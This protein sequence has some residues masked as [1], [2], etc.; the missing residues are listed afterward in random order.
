[1]HKQ[2]KLKGQKLSKSHASL[3]GKGVSKED[4]PKPIPEDMKI[5]P[6]RQLQGIREKSLII[7]ILSRVKGGNISLE[8][9]R[10]EFERQK[11]VLQMQRIMIEKLK[12]SNWDEVVQYHPDS[13]KPH[14]LEKV[15]V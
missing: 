3:K 4:S 9:M 11:T 10:E 6:W 5:T 13:S 2:G 1:L 14:V 8:K 12:C 15:H 7:A